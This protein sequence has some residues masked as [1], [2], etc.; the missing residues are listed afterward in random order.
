MYFCVEAPREGMELI[1]VTAR[2]KAI[3]HDSPRVRWRSKERSVAERSRRAGRA[4][5]GFCC[6]PVPLLPSAL[7]CPLS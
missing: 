1:S 3:H 7:C 4:C 5:A 2:E 6:C